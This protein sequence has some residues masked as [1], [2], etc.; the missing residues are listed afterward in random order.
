MERLFRGAQSTKSIAPLGTMRGDIGRAQVGNTEN[1]TSK[2][3]TLATIS[4]CC[5]AEVRPAPLQILNMNVSFREV[6]RRPQTVKSNSLIIS[7]RQV[8]VQSWPLI[9][10]IIEV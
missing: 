4:Y 8:G 6:D 5:T 2:K 3:Q 9:I 1:S 10:S 7:R